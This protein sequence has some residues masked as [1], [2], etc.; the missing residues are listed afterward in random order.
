MTTLISNKV[1]K[2]LQIDID[3]IIHRKDPKGGK[4]KKV[5]EFGIDEELDDE[6]QRIMSSRNKQE[7]DDDGLGL[8]DDAQDI[9]PKKVENL[10]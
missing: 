7:N 6:D 10:Q 3:P 8:I 9:E 2:Q 1:V 5:N 4:K